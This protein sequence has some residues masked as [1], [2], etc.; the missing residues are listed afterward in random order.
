MINLNLKEKILAGEYNSQLKKIY[1]TDEKVDVQ[2]KRYASLLDDYAE[3]FTKSDEIK[4][5]SAPGRT[6]VGGNH[7]DHNHGKVLAAGID[8]DAVAAVSENSTN[9]INVK[10]KNY[11]INSLDITD[12]S[13]HESE[14]DSSQALLRGVCAGFVKWGYK[15]GGFNAVTVNDVLKG[16]GMSSSASYEVLLGTILNHLYNDGKI[17]PVEIAKIAQYA[18]NEYFGKPC[19]LMDQ[20]ACSVGSFIT[21]D[22][23]N[24]E[25]PTIENIPFD[26]ADCGHALCIVDTKADH[27]DLTDDYAAVRTEMQNVASYFGKK[28]LREVSFEDFSANISA[29]RE[30]FGDRAVL[31]AIHFYEENIRVEKEVAALKSGDFENFKKLVTN[32]GYSSFMYNQNV[33]TF[34]NSAQQP[35]AVALAVTE[36][37]LA[38]KGAFRVHGGGFAGTIQAFVP[39]DML[40]EYKTKIEELLGENTCYVLNIRPIGGAFVF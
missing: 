26:F 39:L 32:S 35:L 33:S 36:K 29:I 4:F 1:I 15:I 24:P 16:S 23:E 10:S 30:K 27:A 18:E 13:I 19:G 7:T 40:N 28:V 34:K 6:E 9:I 22:F 3:F 20:T 2:K 37:T 11:K 25:N 21:I 12:L 38:G 31:R 8:L 5:F 17:S 14:K